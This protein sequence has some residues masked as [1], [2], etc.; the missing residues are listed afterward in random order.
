MDFDF[1]SFFEAENAINAIFNGV[2]MFPDPKGA[3]ILPPRRSGQGSQNTP[4]LSPGPTSTSI[5]S[6]ISIY[7]LGK[8]TR[9]ESSPSSLSAQSV[10]EMHT[11]VRSEDRPPSPPNLNKAPSVYTDSSGQLHLAPGKLHVLL[12]TFQWLARLTLHRSGHVDGHCSFPN[13]PKE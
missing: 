11:H 8:S 9:S 3:Q 2:P 4:K 10:D 5:P 6:S 7:S 1:D 12:I 13:A